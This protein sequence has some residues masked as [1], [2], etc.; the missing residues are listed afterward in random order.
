VTP[1]ERRGRNISLH[2]P[3]DELPAC[4]LSEIRTP[5]GRSTSIP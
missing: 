2:R 4:Y 3:L 5:G 1:E